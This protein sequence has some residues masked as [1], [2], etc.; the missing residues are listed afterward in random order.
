DKGWTSG[1]A[2]RLV[3]QWRDADDAADAVEGPGAHLRCRA[4]GT[5]N[6]GGAECR[7]WWRCDLPEPDSARARRK[8][9]REIQPDFLR[10]D[11]GKLQ[12]VLDGGAGLGSPD[13][14]HHRSAERTVPTADS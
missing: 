6:A 10:S 11:D 1:S 5:E 14:T 12:P 3:Q 9:Q 2:G 7:R 13:V 8:R 4:G